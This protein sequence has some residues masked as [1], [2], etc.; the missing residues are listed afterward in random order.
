MLMLQTVHL[1][2]VSSSFSNPY[3]DRVHRLPQVPAPAQPSSE[4]MSRKAL[5]ILLT[6]LKST[7]VEVLVSVD[8]K[9]LADMLNSLDATLTKN[10]GGGG[11]PHLILTYPTH[12]CRASDFAV[13]EGATEIPASSGLPNRGIRILRRLARVAPGKAATAIRFLAYPG[14]HHRCR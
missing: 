11:P 3:L 7:L 13:S 14:S 12:L 5:G 6:F 2:A 10:P 1:R 8:P 9:G 4:V